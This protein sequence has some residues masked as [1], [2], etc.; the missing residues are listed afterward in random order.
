MYIELPRIYDLFM[1][2]IDYTFWAAYLLDLLKTRCPPGGQVLDMGC[3]T[4]ALSIPLAK[5]GYRVIAA[6][7]SEQMLMAAAENA[8]R[9]GR[10]AGIRIGQKGRRHG[11]RLRCGELSAW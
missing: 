8:R 10:R 7:Q 2:N 3:G 4:G 6:D 11:V 5:A 1:D 9:A